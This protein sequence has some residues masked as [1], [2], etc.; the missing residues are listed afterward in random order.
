MGARGRA[1]RE[2][3]GLTKQQ[4]AETLDIG[5]SR[6]NQMETDGVQGLTVIR[7]W[8]DALGLDPQDLAFGTPELDAPKKKK[9]RRA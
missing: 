2:A 4:M 1:R 7:Q 8:A 5:L 3:L 6:M 9:A